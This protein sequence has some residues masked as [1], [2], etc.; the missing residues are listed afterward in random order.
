MNFLK[1]ALIAGATLLTAPAMAQECAEGQRLFEHEFILG[2][3]ACIPENPQR[4]AFTS[5][6]GIAG[7]VLGVE[8]I[9]Q[10]WF[11]KGFAVNYPGAIDPT[12]FSALPDIDYFPQSN[13]ETLL[14]ADPD[15]IVAVGSAG[16]EINKQAASIAPVILTNLIGNAED[17][18]LEEQMIAALVGKEAEEQAMWDAFQARIEKLKADLADTPSKFAVVRVNNDGL[19]EVATPLILGS[20]ILLQAGW[21]L[22]DN[23]ILEKDSEGKPTQFWIQ[24]S[25]E[26]LQQLND[27]DYI[28]QLPVFP[29]Q[30]ASIGD[31]LRAGEAWQRLPAVKAGRVITTSGDGQQYLRTNVP[32]AHLIIDDV[33]RGVFKKEASEM[34]NPNPF[35]DWL[36]QN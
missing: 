35:A 21:T 36:A 28:V 6:D 8:P 20:Q 1:V 26:N 7:L 2:G 25:E 12:T 23:V 24:L 4:I 14:A 16:E 5:T 31:N 9:V 19:F 11:T 34:G 27:V 29:G 17:W 22:G 10:N 30:D 15:L 3:S 18:R 33:Y 13:V 32:Y